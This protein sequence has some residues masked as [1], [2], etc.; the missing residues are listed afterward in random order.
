MLE[1]RKT[2]ITASL[3][4]EMEWGL[5][6]RAF[7]L[8]LR[9][10]DRKVFKDVERAGGGSS[11]YYCHCYCHCHYCHC[12]YHHFHCH[13]HHYHRHC[14]CHYHHYQHCCCHYHCHCHYHYFVLGNKVLGGFLLL[15][16]LG[17]VGGLEKRYWKFQEEKL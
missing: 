7:K 8:S 9:G 5:L 10:I 2:C 15:V 12:H 13:Y 14:L 3:H 11:Y 17:G 4:E 1:S 6:C 16:F